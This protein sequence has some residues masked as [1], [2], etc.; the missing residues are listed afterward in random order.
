MMVSFRLFNTTIHRSVLCA[1]LFA[2]TVCG[3]LRGQPW[4][5]L[6][7]V[8]S[9][10]TGRA[11]IHTSWDDG[12]S[13]FSSTRFDERLSAAA[14]GYGWK[15]LPQGFIY[16]TYLSHPHEPRLGTQWVSD[17]D[18]GLLWES[19]LGGRLGI[20]RWGATDRNEGVQLDFMG[21]VSVRIDPRENTDVD[22]MDF[23]MALPLTWGTGPHR[24]KFG[25]THLSSHLGDE[26]LISN[27]GYDRLNY[28]R[29]N[30]TF[31]YSY[32]STPDVRL[33]AE[34]SYAFINIVAEKWRFAFGA[35]YAPAVPTGRRGAP[36]FAI[37]GDLREEVDF[38]GAVSAQM[39]WSWRADAPSTGL[40]RTGLYLYNG[41][42]SQL[43]FYDRFERQLG[44]GLW[45]D[46]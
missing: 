15:L 35:E 43:S 46:F 44:W 29:D 40:L 6:E 17:H 33:Y 16:P 5:G 37:N 38:G 32:Y 26:F 12:E 45:Y 9:V 19:S 14:D 31:G 7:D 25:Y 24:F 1:L 30:L 11:S 39:G 3:S 10:D 20:V 34:A 2:L 22:A 4:V 21:G 13:G 23:R 8:G 42:S 28:V 36:F 27:P 18:D 41:K